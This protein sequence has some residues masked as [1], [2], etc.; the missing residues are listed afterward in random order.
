[1]DFSKYSIQ[2]LNQSLKSIDKEAYPEN[3]RA[4]LLEFEKR[5]PEIEQLS[6]EEQ[7]EF[8]ISIDQRLN[9]LSW[10][11]ISTCTGFIIVA[12]FF[13]SR[14]GDFIGTAIYLA[15]AVFNGIAGYMLLKRR[16]LGFEVSYVNQIL[17]LFTFNIGTVFYSYTGLG[18]LLVGIENGLFFKFSI[19]NPDFR[20]YFG[21]DLGSFGFGIDLVALFFILVLNSCRDSSEAQGS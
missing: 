6:K 20:L 3:Y 11:Q 13:S 4:L 5:R 18:S 8:S 1:M 10:L 2:E 15:I 12:L 16:E 19:I 7:E 14:G 21:D 17:Q 9:L